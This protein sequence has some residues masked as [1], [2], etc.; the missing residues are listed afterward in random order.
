MRNGLISN[1]IWSRA[2]A[3]HKGSISAGTNRDPQRTSEA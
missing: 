2:D 3:G 1:V